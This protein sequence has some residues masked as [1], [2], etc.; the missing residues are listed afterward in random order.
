M[1]GQRPP[2]QGQRPADRDRRRTPPP[3]RKSEWIVPEG[4]A[5]YTSEG[6]MYEP[7]R[8]P[9][10]EAAKKP[11]RPIEKKKR[12]PVDKEKIAVWTRAFFVRFV[13][14]L[15]IVSLMGA[16]WY[17]TEF[18]PAPEKRSGKVTVTFEN[19]GSYETSAA[20]AYR[21]DV[22]Y[23]DLTAISSYLDMVCVGSINSMRFI[24]KSTKSETSSGVGNE[25]YAIFTSGSQTVLIN[26]TSLSLEA[27]C[28]SIESHIWVPL[29][30]VESYVSGIL[31]DRGTTGTDIV[32]RSSTPTVEEDNKKEKEKVKVSYKIK[33]QKPLHHVEYP[34]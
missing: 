21:D 19:M 5:I 7:R 4:S 3:Q 26:G 8:G 25:E 31:C 11:A 15:L 12:K 32:I 24:C 1:Q 10:P 29:S 16:W 33:A 9:R 20:T 27:P 2:M 13:A 30:F 6:R 18:N 22:L 14:M 28:R 17:N 23:V 34:S